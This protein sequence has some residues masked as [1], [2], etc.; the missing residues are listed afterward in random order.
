MPPV[1]AMLLKK[2]VIT[3]KVTSLYEVTQGKAIYVNNPYDINEWINR[4][5][6]IDIQQTKPF[7]YNLY[8]KKNVAIKYL[9]LFYDITRYKLK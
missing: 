7:N 1:E 3:T 8:N 6:E 9:N 4:M 2:L 5:K